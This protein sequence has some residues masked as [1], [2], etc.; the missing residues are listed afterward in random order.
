MDSR[1]MWYIHR[2]EF[3]SILYEAANEAG[4]KFL[5]GSP[6]E[7][8]NEIEAAIYL[9][10]GKE[11]K[12]D[13]VIGAD[14]IRSKIRTSISK[15]KTIEFDKSPHCAYRAMIPETVLLSDPETAGILKVHE[16]ELWIGPESH[17]MAYAVKDGSNDILYNFALC[18]RGDGETGKWNEPGDLKEMKVKYSKWEPGLQWQSRTEPRW[19]NVS[20]EQIRLLIYRTC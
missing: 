20:P 2:A 18:H 3:Q 7:K 12:A 16:S 1:G 19:R 8:L 4:V 6:V 5:L 13:L 15:D 14:G 10:D 17:I 9:R 11:L